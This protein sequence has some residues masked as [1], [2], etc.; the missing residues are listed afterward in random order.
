LNFKENV[1]IWRAAKN[2]SDEDKGIIVQ[3]CDA[4]SVSMQYYEFVPVL[5]CQFDKNIF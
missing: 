5:R 1:F 4:V 3:A 2:G